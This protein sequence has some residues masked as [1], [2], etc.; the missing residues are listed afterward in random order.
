MTIQTLTLCVRVSK[1]LVHSIGCLFCIAVGVLTGCVQCALHRGG[2]G[3]IL[4]GLSALL[5]SRAESM[6]I[7]HSA[8]IGL[9]LYSLSLS[10]VL[11]L[12]VCV[13]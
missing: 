13:W 11:S 7:G 9:S 6:C 10:L 3:V 8:N 5:Y 12:C 1:E 4:L 2:G